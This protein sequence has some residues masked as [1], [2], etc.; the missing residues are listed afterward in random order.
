MNR[1]QRITA[2]VSGGLLLLILL[3]PPIRWEFRGQYRTSSRTTWSP[4]WKPIADWS[5]A[6]D[7]LALEVAIIAVTACLV[8]VS[9]KDKE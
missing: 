1:H 5:L 8:F 3:F 2:Q 9:V 4:I 7:Y 6:W